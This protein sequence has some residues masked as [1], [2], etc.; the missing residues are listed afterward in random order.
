MLYLKQ[1]CQVFRLKVHVIFLG[2]SK[3]YLLYK[4]YL[5]NGHICIGISL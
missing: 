4:N 5:Q 3:D 2:K 1:Y